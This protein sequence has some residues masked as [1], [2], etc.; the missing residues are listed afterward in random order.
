MRGPVTDSPIQ[1]SAPWFTAACVVAGAVALLLGMWLHAAILLG[2]T[3][4]HTVV[5]HQR[6]AVR[7]AGSG[8]GLTAQIIPRPSGDWPSGQQ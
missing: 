4:V 5:V 1:R 6:R 8:H 7:R 3:A 2:G